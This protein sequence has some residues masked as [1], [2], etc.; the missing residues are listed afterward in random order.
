[1]ELTGSGEPTVEKVRRLVVVQG[2]LVQSHAAR[3]TSSEAWLGPPTLRADDPDTG[4]QEGDELRRSRAALVK[5]AAGALAR[6]ASSAWPAASGRRPKRLRSE[7]PPRGLAVPGW[8]PSL[9]NPVGTA[10]WGRATFPAGGG[11]VGSVSGYEHDPA[12]PAA[13]RATTLHGGWVAK[14]GPPTSSALFASTRT[15]TGPCCAS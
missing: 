5:T 9:T 12:R 14:G 8:S 7:G 10:G 11:C 15:Y 2:E 1:M 3:I 4:V 6:P 13:S